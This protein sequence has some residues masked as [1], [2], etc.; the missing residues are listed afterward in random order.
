ML[1]E[2]SSTVAASRR[3][4]YKPAEPRSHSTVAVVARLAIR[5]C[6][7]PVTPWLSLSSASFTVGSSTTI[8]GIELNTGTGRPEASCQ[9]ES[10]CTCTLL[11]ADHTS[12]CTQRTSC[13]SGHY[14]ENSGSS[15]GP[16]VRTP[17][18][19]WRYHS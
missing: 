13:A 4:I 16:V 6:E 15:C 10:K 7:G 12:C 9:H 1:Y 17:G 2:D 3:C 18:T 11:G 14:S 5:P 8:T 19:V